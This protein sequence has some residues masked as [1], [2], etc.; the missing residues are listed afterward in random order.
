MNKTSLCVFQKSNTSLKKESIIVIIVVA[1]VLIH[2][3]APLLDWLFSL[4]S[5][6]I[7]YPV[8][9]ATIKT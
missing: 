4:I 1:I 3:L 7:L 2:I 8:N 6:F 9:A 5:F